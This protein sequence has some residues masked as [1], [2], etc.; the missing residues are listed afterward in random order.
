[1]VHNNL[2]I[3]SG[4]FGTITFSL[5]LVL[6]KYTILKYPKMLPAEMYFWKQVSASLLTAL[7]LRA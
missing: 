1:M 3:V 7:A 4:F 5:M 6:T 2:A